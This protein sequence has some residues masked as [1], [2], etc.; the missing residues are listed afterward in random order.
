MR[1]RNM[2]CNCISKS[3]FQL[4]VHVSVESNRRIDL[5]L[6]YYAL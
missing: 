3:D 5:V 2:S 6:H 1:G 4:H